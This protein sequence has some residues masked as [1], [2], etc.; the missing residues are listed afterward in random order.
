MRPEVPTDGASARVGDIP[1]VEVYV[2]TRNTG[3]G[4]THKGPTHRN[5]PAQRGAPHNKGA[6]HTRGATHT[7]DTQ[8][9]TDVHIHV[10]SVR[11]I[12]ETAICQAGM[13]T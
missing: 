13:D 11:R 1:R 10:C 2:E 9:D 12:G 8:T 6:T 5:R 7:G 4:G 3:G